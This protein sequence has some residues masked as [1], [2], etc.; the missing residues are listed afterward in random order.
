LLA[1]EGESYRIV[2]DGGYKHW[3][4]MWW[5]FSFSRW[6]DISVESTQVEVSVYVQSGMTPLEAIQSATI[7]SARAM[8][9]DRDSGSIEV[10]KRADMILVDGNRSRTSQT[11]KEC[12]GLWRTAACTAPQNFGAWASGRKRAISRVLFP[13]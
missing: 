8:N 1:S 13:A 4:P 9:L 7:V 10:G 5:N 3:Y 2:G 11:F 6:H 12:R